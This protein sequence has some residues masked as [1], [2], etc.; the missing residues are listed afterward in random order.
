VA[1]KFCVDC[2]WVIPGDNTTYNCL[3]PMNDNLYDWFNPST[4]DV[5]RDIRR[6]SVTYEKNTCDE[7]AQKKKS[8]SSK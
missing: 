4:G 6:S 3:N 1:D 8:P 5:I 7:F 2:K